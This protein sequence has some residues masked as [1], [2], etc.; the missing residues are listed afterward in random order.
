MRRACKRDANHAELVGY[1]EQAGWYV[2]DTADVGPKA[3]PGFPDVLACYAG[4]IVGIE[5]KVGKE[6]LTDDE[7]KFHD[8]H[9]HMFGMVVMRNAEDV[10][11]LTRFAS[12]QA[13]RE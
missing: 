10:A 2:I 4:Q 1:L 11:T 7:Q 12:A 13:R 5:F 6:P 9:G 3:I 8:K